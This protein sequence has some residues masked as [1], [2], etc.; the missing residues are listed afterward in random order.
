MI[1][2]SVNFHLAGENVTPEKVLF[3]E[4][5]A[6]TPNHC[7]Q[8]TLR[9]IKEPKKNMARILS[10]PILCFAEYWRNR[11]MLHVSSSLLVW[12][13]HYV[14]VLHFLENTSRNLGRMSQTGLLWDRVRWPL[15]AADHEKW[16]SFC[17]FYPNRSLATLESCFGQLFSTKQFPCG[18]GATAGTVLL[19]VLVSRRNTMWTQAGFLWLWALPQT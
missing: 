12:G 10:L 17:F 19:L 6:F 11:R 18:F 14:K 13:S 8:W 4:S 16:E 5:S 15:Q 7:R 2:S 3:H 9:N 1:L